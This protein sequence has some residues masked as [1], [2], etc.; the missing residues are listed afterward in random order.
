[1]SEDKKK[2]LVLLMRNIRDGNSKKIMFL[3]F[4]FVGGI[5]TI[6][7]YIWYALFLKI[8]VP[9]MVSFTLA[10]VISMIGSFFLNC[11][12]TFK[13]KPTLSKF[14]KFPLTTLAN[15]C[16]STVTLYILVNI[17]KI[18]EYFA[19]PMA[20]ILP[21]P[22][23]FLMT[24]LLLNEDGVKFK[25]ISGKQISHIMVVS[26]AFLVIAILTHKR[27]IYDEQ[28]FV[29]NG[30]DSMEQFMY[31]IPFIEKTIDKGNMLWSWTYG[32]GGD[33]LAEFSY[34]YTSSPFF[35]ILYLVRHLLKITLS[36]D[37]TIDLKLCLSIFKQC[38]IMISMYGLLRY[39]NKSWYTSFIGAITYGVSI[40]FI[41][42]A[43]V[44]DFMTDAMVW[45]PVTILGYKY[46]Q[47][48]KKNFLM[49]LGISLT[50]LNNFYFAYMSLIF[51]CIYAVVFTTGE[52]H[53]IKEKVKSYF[54]KG[55]QYGSK[56]IVSIGIS[57]FLFVPAIIAFMN[58]DRFKVAYNVPKLFSITFYK[59]MFEN[60]FLYNDI[61]GVPLVA[62]LIFAI[63]MKKVSIE[64][65]KK[66]L[67]SVIFL[68]LLMI[69]MSYSMFN[70]FSYIADRWIYIFIFV[71]A[72]S[73]P[74][75]IEECNLTRTRG[76]AIIVL[77]ILLNMMMMYT[78]SNRVGAKL[79]VSEL[80]IL[81]MGIASIAIL[82]VRN[83]FNNSYL[84]ILTEIL[85][86]VCVLVGSLKNTYSY[87]E[88]VYTKDYD[89]ALGK[90]YNRGM[91]NQLERE[92]L[93]ETVPENA[94]FYRTIY[95]IAYK[96]NTPMN[97]M[98]YGASAY[99]SL[100]NKNVHKWMKSEYNIF[101]KNVSPSRFANFDSR[102]F[103][104]SA[105]GVRYKLEYDNKQEIYGYKIHSTNDKY[106]LYENS[107]NVGIDLWY[108]SYESADK[109]ESLNYAER[110]TLLLNTALIDKK[111]D[112]V[113]KNRL[114]FDTINELNF[115][116]NQ[117]EFINSKYKDDKLYVE[118][119]SQIIIPIDNIYKNKQGEIL[120]TINIVPQDGSEFSVCINDKISTKQAED[121]QWAYPLNEFTFKLDGDISNIKLNLTPGTY[122]I[123]KLEAYHSSYEKYDEWIENMNKYNIENLVV[124]GPHISGNINNNEKGILA[125]SIPYKNGWIAKV[126]GKK[127]ELL[128]VNGI[129]TGI[130]LEPG[131]H[132][133]E[134]SY[135]TP[136]FILGILIS[137]TS[138]IICLLWYFISKRK[139]KK[140]SL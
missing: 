73:I 91:D 92:I 122:T 96:E 6:H 4:A 123:N 53:S 88:K 132:K 97:Y 52:G 112:R 22:I 100:I 80:I 109:L 90:L 81:L 133:L 56:I 58:A 115:D 129:F 38:S 33:V 36:Y 10:F 41:R 101:Q 75:W 82:Y 107:N 43:I 99:N 45:L 76:I 30:T 28:I 65:K 130:E 69:P 44:F 70:G 126:D 124:D 60:I 9:Y 139:S 85:I 7:N 59:S 16:I 51:Y 74:N 67:L 117:A 2:N 54:I 106:V 57:A 23:T 93:K 79:Q 14:I 120:F 20:S 110:D 11:Y 18:Q 78:K 105:F 125:L 1:M 61:I 136:G 71:I 15:Y 8:S 86:I 55:F 48:T 134:L 35:Y 3:R 24:K 31:F 39:E 104:E 12:F 27:Y 32:L 128:K 77:M 46:W 94:E 113:K 17:I 140:I 103:L 135:I 127:V 26:I 63:P 25:K 131:Q 98:N 111:I 137:I 68:L 21:I 13:T 121:Y 47:K 89:V 108:D 83:L 116:L 62:L 95:E 114:Q 40:I 118:E 37:R 50:V 84:K 66:T 34:Y 5:N 29:H 119:N 138:I 64:T 42:N 49:I 19:G 87:M 102:L 72:Y